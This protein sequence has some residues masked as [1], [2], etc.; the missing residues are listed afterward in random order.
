M[1]KIVQSLDVCFSCLAVPAAKAK[2]EGRKEVVESRNKHTG[3]GKWAM[4]FLQ[5][6][7]RVGVGGPGIIWTICPL[8]NLNFHS[9]IKEELLMP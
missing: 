5:L 3:L 6:Q 7:S 2:Q 8:R 1:V 9:L 4:Q